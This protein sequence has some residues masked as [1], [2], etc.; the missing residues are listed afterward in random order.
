MT[1]AN[2][3]NVATI[4]YQTKTGQ[5]TRQVTRTLWGGSSHG[6]WSF[7]VDG[8]LRIDVHPSGHVYEWF[9]RRERKVG[10]EATFRDSLLYTLTY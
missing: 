9:N 4:S 1:T 8:H 7:E 6:V 2:T 3:T 5:V 10:E